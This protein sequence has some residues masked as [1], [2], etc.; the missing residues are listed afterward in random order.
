LFQS[1]ISNAGLAT[2]FLSSGVLS[3]PV[4]PFGQLMRDSKSHLHG[5][6]AKTEHLN[7]RDGDSSSSESGSMRYLNSQTSGKLFPI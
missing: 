4:G 3:G 7:K 1:L 6:S 2:V 5:S